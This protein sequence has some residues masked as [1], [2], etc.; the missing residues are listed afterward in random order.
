MRY[1]VALADEG[2]RHA[3]SAHPELESGVNIVGESVCHGAVAESL[4][5]DHVPAAEALAGV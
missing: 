4:G 3:V 2:V 1:A 5:V